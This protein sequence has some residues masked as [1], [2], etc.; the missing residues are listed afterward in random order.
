MYD[1]FVVNS[2]KCKKIRFFGQEYVKFFFQAIKKKFLET[3]ECEHF[4]QNP[5]TC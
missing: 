4:N 1:K 5:E 2:D 3:I